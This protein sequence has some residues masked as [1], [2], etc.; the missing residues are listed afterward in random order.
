MGDIAD[1]SFLKSL[2]PFLV[3]FVLSIVFLHILR[4]GG[5]QRT[6]YIVLSF[7][8]LM[9]PRLLFLMGRP[10][11]ALSVLFFPAALWGILRDRRV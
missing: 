2:W 11:A 1:F 6:F 4:S 3:L 5:K 8:L 10:V 7:F 9:Y